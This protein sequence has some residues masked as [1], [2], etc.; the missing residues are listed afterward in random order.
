MF[1][2]PCGAWVL[3]S[4][5]AVGHCCPFL[6]PLPKSPFCLQVAHFKDYIPQ[7]FPGGH[8]MILDSEVLLID[9]KTGKPLPFGTLGVHK[10]LAQGH[11][12]GKEH[13]CTCGRGRMRAV[14]LNGGESV[15]HSR[16][17]LF[18]V[19]ELFL[20]VALSLVV[21]FSFFT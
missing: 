18:F 10:V 16:L 20:N 9:T 21:F 15:T 6:C 4:G 8:S 12:C 5:S 3:L 11:T 17:G 19:S 7:A 1:C 13:V 2:V 14:G